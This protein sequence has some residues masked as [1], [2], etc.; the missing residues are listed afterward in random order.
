MTNN[1]VLNNNKVLKLKVKD[2]F[3]S[4]LRL[5]DDR[6]VQIEDLT[7]C[8]RFAFRYLGN[9][10]SRSTLFMISEWKESADDIAQ[11]FAMLVF[12][13]YYPYT[14]FQFGNPVA[15]GSWNSYLLK[16]LGSEKLSLWGSQVWNHV[17][18]S[19][20]KKTSHIR[21][22]FNGA[23]STVDY[24]DPELV[25]LTI[26]EDFLSKIYILRCA[27]NYTP[28]CSSPKAKLTDFNVWDRALT[29]DEAL[30]WTSC[31]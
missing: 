19:Y 14:F 12:G 28:D 11:D 17:C 20:E 31:R 6:K 2:S 15:K 10:L 24:H 23:L 1:L 9:F 4:G 30:D 29:R 26:P 16:K 27:Y 5:D 22:V 3:I 18:L 25:N 13:A 7:I 21:V 8:A